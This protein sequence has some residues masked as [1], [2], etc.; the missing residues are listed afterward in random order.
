MP[1]IADLT[2]STGPTLDELV[3]EII[4]TAQGYSIAPDR[5]VALSSSLDDAALSFTVTGIV[6]PGLVEIGDEL[7]Y[8]TS[9]DEGTGTCTVHPRGRGWQG[10]TA[11]SHAVGDVVVDGPALPRHRT[12]AAINDVISSMFPSLYAVGVT[13]AVTDGLF[14]EVP[15]DAEFVL[16]VRRYGVDG[17]WHRVRAWEAEMASASAATTGKAVRLPTVGVGHDVRVVY[18]VRPEQLT[19][20]DATWS[21]TGLSLAVK[22]IVV[23]GVL[24]RFAQVLDVG[25]LTDRFITSRGDTQQPQLTTGFQMARALKA[26]YQAALD[27]EAHALR[28]LY[29]ARSHFVR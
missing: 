18:A 23:T 12:A 28:T 14:V 6:S 3:T 29:P 25:R 11:A 17:E 1:I 26:D 19:T 10:S 21:T 27:R 4:H 20:G 16:D 9:V 8:V 22:D 7:I 13:E 5:I 24:S 2:A 15:A